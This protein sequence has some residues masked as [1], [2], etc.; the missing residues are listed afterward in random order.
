MVGRKP[1]S[2]VRFKAAQVF[3]HTRPGGYPGCKSGRQGSWRWVEASQLGQ[4]TV[5]CEVASAGAR[6]QQER[7]GLKMRVKQAQQALVGRFDDRCRD[8]VGA[9]HGQAVNLALRK[10]RLGLAGLCLR[11]ANTTRLQRQNTACLVSICGEMPAV[12][13]HR[14]GDPFIGEI[15]EQAVDQAQHRVAGLNLSWG[16]GLVKTANQGC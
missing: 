14:L 16:D 12:M 11:H 4:L 3:H 13:E 6:S 8:G 15:F 1:I 9:D 10:L 2:V 5:H 7:V